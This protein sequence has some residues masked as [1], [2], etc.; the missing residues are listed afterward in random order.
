[1]PRISIEH[2]ASATAQVRGMTLAQKAAV[3][4]HVHAQQPHMLGSLLVQQQLGVSLERMDVLA[5]ILL[6]CFLAMQKA[7]RRWPVITEDLI[8]QQMDRFVGAMQ[9]QSALS[10]EIGER[11]LGEY[12]RQHPEQ[13][14]LAVVN[15]ELTA[16]LAGL[17]PLESDKHLM[18]AAIN[19]VNCIANVPLPSDARGTHARR[20]PGKR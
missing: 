11:A 5:N 17:P 14:L 20:R 15:A 10:R 4:D 19:Y 12:I 6:I 9:F 8:E 7:R 18:A 3:M 2:L 1:M 13:P 16:G